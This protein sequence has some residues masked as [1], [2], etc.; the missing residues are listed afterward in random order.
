M[1]CTRFLSFRV[2]FTSPTRL[3]EHLSACKSS[4]KKL[5]FRYEINILTR[6]KN[7]TSRCCYYMQ[8]TKQHYI[9]LKWNILIWKKSI[10][11]IDWRYKE[12]KMNFVVWILL[13]NGMKW[14]LMTF[15]PMN[16]WNIHV[17]KIFILFINLFKFKKIFS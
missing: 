9:I 14:Y 6:T 7:R 15:R 3:S 2:H 13:V 1:P 8:I 5:R 17:T 10:V 4:D 16:Y 11:R 12:L